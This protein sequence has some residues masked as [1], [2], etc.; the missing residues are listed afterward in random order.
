[1]GRQLDQPS[2][3]PALL[4]ASAEVHGKDIKLWCCTVPA[5]IP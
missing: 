2:I 5:G 3:V 4:D 1:M